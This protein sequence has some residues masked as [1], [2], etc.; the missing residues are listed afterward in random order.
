MNIA[1]AIIAGGGTGGHLF[2]GITVAREIQRRNS[3]A[4]ILFVGAERGIEARVVPQEGFPL[5][6]LPLGGVKGKGW[7]TRAKNMMA[8]IEGVFS[9][10]T[11]LREFKPQ[12]VIGVGGYAS[13]PAV[14]AAILLGYPRIIMEQNALPGLANRMLSRWVNF[15][16]VTDPRTTHYFGS[17]AV[18]TGNPIRPQF[19]TISEKEHVAPFTVLVF[20]GSQGAQSINNAVRGSLSHLADWKG[21]LRFVHQTGAAQLEEIKQAYA[22]AGFEADVRSF[23]DEFHLQYA[24]ADLIVSRAGQTTL[25]ELRAA[26]RTA[27]LIPLPT[28]A[29]DHQTFNAQAMVDEDAAIMISNKDLSGESLSRTIRSLLSDPNRLSQMER[30]SRRLA[31]LDAEE[32]IVDLAERAAEETGET[33]QK[34]GGRV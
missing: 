29:D 9:A 24:L 16:A 34:R 6:T 14:C 19:K 27:I 26:G 28:A 18:V 10:R 23:F 1:R 8:A 33:A 20:G 25:A 5:K 13:F 21:K 32:R 4:Q 15:A 30:N 17:R 7:G 12:V 31:I 11:I 22:S 2:P 3:A